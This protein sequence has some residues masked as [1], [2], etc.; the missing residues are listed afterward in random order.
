M[1][2]TAQ[3]RFLSNRASENAVAPGELAHYQ[4]IPGKF[5][6]PKDSRRAVGNSQEHRMHISSTRAQKDLLSLPTQV[7]SALSQY[8]TASLGKQESEEC[9]MI[10]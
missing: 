8:T 2:A 10:Q 6:L 9:M 4:Q 3:H 5:V 7:V 1:G